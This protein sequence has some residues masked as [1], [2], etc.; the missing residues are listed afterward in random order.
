MSK[1]LLPSSVL[2][3]D[4]KVLCASQI[5]EHVL[6]ML[7]ALQG[8]SL[9]RLGLASGLSLA[10]YMSFPGFPTMDLLIQL[11]A[12]I[13][14]GDITSAWSL[15]KLALGVAHLHELLHVLWIRSHNQAGLCQLALPLQTGKFVPMLKNSI[16]SVS[17]NRF[18]KLERSLNLQLPVLVLQMLDAA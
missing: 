10:M 3:L 12:L 11:L 17:K 2:Q 7:D 15:L 1:A 14:L 18:Q 13:H 16:D 8:R 9:R 4:S 5:G 6:C